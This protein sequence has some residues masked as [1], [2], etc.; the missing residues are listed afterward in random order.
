M[1][2]VW[3]DYES[4]GSRVNF[5][6]VLEASFVLTDDRFKVL[7]KMELRCR[8]KP[9]VVPNIGAL[10]VNN[11]SVDTLQKA[12]LSHYQL[13]L[14][15]HNWFEKF[16][17][18]FFSGYN[19]TGFDMEFYR[20]M[21]FK[22]LLPNWYQTNTSGNKIHD[23][24]PHIR[25]AKLVNRNVIATK[26]NQKGNDSFRLA[27]IAEVGNF[28][29]GI[30]HT[31]LVDCL[32]TIEV[33][34]KIKNGTPEIWDASLK[35]AHRSDAEKVIDKEKVICTFE[36]F[37]SKAR[38]YCTKFIFFHPVYR[39]A[40]LWDL[41]QHPKDY[42]DLDRQS[43]TKAI[44]KAPKVIRT[45]KHNKNPLILK[46]EYSLNFE[47]YSEI[48][49]DELMKR[50]KLIDENPKFVNM[51]KSIIETEAQAKQESNQIELEFEESLYSGGL[52]ISQS[53]KSNMKKFHEVDLKGKLNLLEK[54]NE[55]RFVYFAKCIL[56]EEFPKENLPE[57]FFKEMHRH[58]A[59]RL[60][61][62]TGYEKWETFDSFYL[63]VDNK[64]EHYK[65]DK[66]KLKLLEG[67]DNYVQSM[68]KKFENA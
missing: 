63:E 25:V 31:S 60:T 33:A 36:Y 8:L 29:H 14:E 11:I 54:F 47:P 41:K 37:Y 59:N 17:P 22:N 2:F 38:A 3:F 46:K 44:M 28:N 61:S 7:E 6:Q 66:N 50:S 32:N 58:F 68:Q 52:N 5:D 20:R 16:T 49:M 39:W 26:L 51:I 56:Y 64:R 43:L 24:L 34:K 35:T 12:P 9:N 1:N 67:Y 10:L 19:I 40:I 18:A 57:G 27:D 53:D 48:G 13:V 15:N 65:D 23:V 42:I 62:K 45:C 21:L 55:E 30:S 4:S